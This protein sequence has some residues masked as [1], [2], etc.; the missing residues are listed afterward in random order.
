VNKDLKLPMLF[1]LL[2]DVGQSQIGHM[3]FLLGFGLSYSADGIFLKNL[4]PPVLHNVAGQLHL[5]CLVMT[6]LAS[7]H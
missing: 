6:I 3:A 1:N 7:R 4:H 2:R 5:V